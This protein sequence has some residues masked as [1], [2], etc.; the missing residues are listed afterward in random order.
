[1]K[2]AVETK[3]VFRTPLLKDKDE[4]NERR[5]EGYEEVQDQNTEHGNLI[6]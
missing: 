4:T 5:I 6:N 3:G 1:M 2:Q